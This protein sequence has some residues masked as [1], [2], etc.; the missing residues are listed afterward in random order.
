MQAIASS[1]DGGSSWRTAPSPL[2]PGIL[3]AAP[4]Q[5][6][7]AVTAG[8][9]VVLVDGAGRAAP[10][11]I[12]PTSP[13]SFGS[14]TVTAPTG[15]GFAVVG[16]RNSAVARAAISNALVPVP[17]TG[18]G[19]GG[20]LG[21]V[22]LQPSGPL[23]QFPSTLLPSTLSVSLPAGGSTDIPYDLL[24]PRTPTPVD[25]MFL[26]DST[27]SMSSVIA[28]LRVRL[29]E[30]V[31][32]LDNAGLNIRFGIGDY[33]DYPE[34]YGT[35][36]RGDWP[37]RLDREVG[38]V[39]RDLQD[40]IARIGAGGGTND[41]R[42]SPLTAL[43]QA[44]TGAGDA[45]YDV[46]F[47]DPG[48]GAQ[49]RRDA[50]K[51]AVVA[52]DTEAHYGGQSIGNGTLNP[53]PDFETTIATLL[54]QDVHMMGLAVGSGPLRDF[55]RLAKGSRTFAPAGGVDCDGDGTRDLADGDPLVCLIG[56]GSVSA[57]GVVTLSG[58]G[59]GNASGLTA[60]LIGLA[61]GIPDV[62][63]VGLTVAQG[64]AF[65][66]ITT[67]PTQ[68]VNLR[69]DNQLAF[70][71]GLHCPLGPASRQRV[72][73]T[74]ATGARALATGTVDLSCGSAG[75]PALPAAAGLIAVAEAAPPPA[76]AQP[77]PNANPNPNPNPNPN[78]NVQPAANAN[79]QP[80]AATQDQD[81][82]QLAFA[83]D[84][85]SGSESPAMA[86]LA[87]VAV[88]GLMTCTA[89]GLVLRRRTAGVFVR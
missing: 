12:S 40:A 87:F 21:P 35:A 84:A 88:V 34:P 62:K 81:Q 43:V 54:R 52:G 46:V 28:E 49:F 78:A 83:E 70:G 79:V 68:S 7:F 20:R 13:G 69:A 18:A 44:S 23:A 26:V 51:L 38:P 53:G 72:V 47:V 33:R 74:A 59:T 30:I 27:G 66:R 17:I 71:V 55:R 19:Q 50:L 5:D 39:D 56:S 15:A 8:P 77:V 14:L 80:G 42:A 89:G 2:P 61:A 45:I 6:L 11:A 9:Q 64:R 85:A 60:A 4:L 63:P 3:A 75:L 58:T 76:P 31:N 29:V 22:L 86:G 16:L 57:G 73:L 25:V 48:E 32:A 36:G 24:V 65:A 1:T 82:Q 67:P 41:G 37:Y 10:T